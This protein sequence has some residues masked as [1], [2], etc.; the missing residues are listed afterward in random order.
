MKKL[1]IL[2][3]ITAVS[4]LGFAGHQAFLNLPG[5]DKKKNEP[6]KI[7]ANPN[8]LGVNLEI[9]FQKGKKH[10][11]ASFVIWIEDMD[12]NYIQT[13]FITKSIG[14]G[15]FEHGDSKSGKWMP[16]EIQRPAA[17]PYWSHKRG[18][19][20][21][22][23]YFTPDSETAVADAYTG[24]TPNGDYILSGKTDKILSGK[25]RLLMEINQAFDWN[26]FW[27]NA[28]YPD[29]SEY[30]TS[31]Q[32]SLIYSVTLDPSLK[33]TEFHLNPIGHGHFSG[34]DGK[35]YTDLSTITTAL[36]IVKKVWVEVK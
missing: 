5:K 20:N 17:L 15:V 16:G 11:H 1:K 13:I 29:D 36:E 25:F 8:G 30:K 22:N 14:N 2:L 3:L 10:S 26:E 33:N 7:V 12:E 9:N 28:K 35:L 24:A 31:C 32:P 6:E 23:G 21:K 19:K 18:L 4:I 27:H 34:K